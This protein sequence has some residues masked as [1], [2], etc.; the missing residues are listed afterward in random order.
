V[1]PSEV[2]VE[3]ADLADGLLL[4]LEEERSRCDRLKECLE[5]ERSEREG[6]ETG[7]GAEVERL[8]VALAARDNQLEQL[9]RRLGLAEVEK[10]QLAR[11]AE[12]AREQAARLEVIMM[13]QREASQPPVDAFLVEEL[14]SKLEASKL[15]EEQLIAEVEAAT[16]SAGSE[17]F[18]I[19]RCGSYGGSIKNIPQE[20]QQQA[21]FFYRR[22]LRAESYRKALVWQKRYLSLLLTS[23][24]ES[25]LLSLSR[26]ARMSG[27]RKMLVADVPP[28]EGSNIRFRVVVHAMVAVSRMQFLV[29]RWKKSKRLGKKFEGRAASLEAE[30]IVKERHVTEEK[31]SPVPNLFQLRPK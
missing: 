19:A 10:V 30:S 1:R 20:P 8:K 7:L 14:E 5:I 21:V 12:A 29:K 26:L 31:S 2:M 25:E 3:K 13:E 23:Y 17:S 4:E 11:D 28:P 16:R 24:Q 22:L 9:G 27:S 18:P 15:R 6:V